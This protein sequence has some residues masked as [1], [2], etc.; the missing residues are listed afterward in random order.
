MRPGDQVTER[1]AA[2]IVSVL[3]LLVGFLSVLP[4]SAATNAPTR[5]TS[6]YDYELV[7]RSASTRVGRALPVLV[8]G[9]MET[10]TASA[11]SISAP[12]SVALVVAAETEAGAASDA[13][14]AGRPYSAL[15]QTK[16]S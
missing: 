5:R 6:P 10:P 7:A 3:L 11:G 12:H 1:A 8:G 15:G 4:A 14:P 16:S 2:V 9:A 13:T